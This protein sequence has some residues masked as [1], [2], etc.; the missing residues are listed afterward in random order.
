MRFFLTALFLILATATGLAQDQK[1]KFGVFATA[2]EV[3]G[4]VPDNFGPEG[5]TYRPNI[6]ADAMATLG[7]AGP[8]RFSAG[9]TYKYNFTTNVSTYYLNGQVS[10]H[11]SVFEPFARFSAGL[12]RANG[13]GVFS[14]EVLIGGDLNFKNFY[15][16]P[17][18]VG[19]RRTGEFL[20]PSERTFQ[21]G[22]GFTI[23]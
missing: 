11:K 16:R 5:T 13:S 6:A 21:T 7:K 20:A 1:F 8:V 15:V 19:F 4:L 18:A 10:Y 2:S 22:F 9:A 23:K 14:R 12:D 17:L 3:K